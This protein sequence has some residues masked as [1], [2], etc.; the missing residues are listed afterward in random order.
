MHHVF[1]NLTSLINE[2]NKVVIMSHKNIDLD[3]FGSSLCLYN[4]VK[5]FNKECYIYTNKRELNRTIIKTQK[6]LKKEQQR[7]EVIGYSKIKKIIDDKTLLIVLDTHIVSIIENEKLLKKIKDVI[8]IDHHIMQKNHIKDTKLTYIDSNL[9]SIVE[10][11]V[12]YLKFLGKGVSPLIA[13]IMLAGIEI[14]TNG[15]KIKTTEKTYEAA[16]YLTSLGAD[17]VIIQELQQESKDDYFKMQ[18]VIEKSEMINK[19]TILCSLDNNPVD[20]KT[21]AK[22][23]EELLKFEDVD[24]S[25]VIGYLNEEI[26]GV[27]ARS[28]GNIDVY[29]VCKKLGG[30]GH[31][32][33]AAAQL[34]NTTIDK[35][36]EKIINLSNGVIE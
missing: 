14:D 27:S 34:T 26:I 35:V 13:S 2:Y 20:K 6:L 16:A 19:N 31:L 4:I 36:K 33:N 17:S 7:Y 5:S 21:L 11:M 25:Y 24:A 22:I 28:L 18:R 9:S 12:N 30:G 10:F 32:S 3:A 1:E 8:I 23:A 15:F 29:D